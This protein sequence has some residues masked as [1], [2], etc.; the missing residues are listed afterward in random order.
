MQQVSL[1]QLRGIGSFGV[2]NFLISVSSYMYEYAH[3]LMIGYFFPIE[4]VAYYGLA[5]GLSVQVRG[6]LGNVVVVFYPAATDLHFRGEKTSLERLY[7]DGTRLMLLVLIPIVLIASFWAEDFYRLW[8]GEK[9]LSGNR[10]P[11][12]ALLLKIILIGTAAMYASGISGQILL[13]IQRVRLVA[14]C[15]TLEAILILS[16][17]LISIRSY[18]L[19]GVAVSGVIG[20]FIVRLF[21]IPFALQRAVGLRVKQVLKKGFLRPVVVSFLLLPLFMLIKLTGQPRDWL[22]LILHGL[23]AG[24]GAVVTI[25]MV[26]V[27]AE[28][29]LQFL[30]EPVQRILKTNRIF[31]AITGKQS[32]I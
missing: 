2:W 19:I 18:G 14:L 16:L 23:F 25:L 12:V 9:Y 4:A 3:M 20:S 31:T 17:S 26:G 28:E 27:T 7:C 22:H 21:V 11:S 5:V 8:V 10:F 6:V 1:G 13:G 32:K 15:V 30:F 29:R 24:V